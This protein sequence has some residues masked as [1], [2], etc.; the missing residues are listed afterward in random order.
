MSN[1]KLLLAVFIALQ[2]ATAGAG[3]WHN[4]HVQS[5]RQLQLQ[6][7]ADQLTEQLQQES[8]FNAEILT[9]AQ[10]LTA[11][12]QLALQILAAD[13]STSVAVGLEPESALSLQV[14]LTQGR[15]LKLS[16]ASEAFPWL[17]Q[18]LSAAFVFVAGL[19]FHFLQRRQQQSYLPLWQVLQNNT[20]LTET[21]PPG[22]QPL[23]TAIEQLVK[24]ESDRS[25]Q[26]QNLQ[27]QLG[28]T[29][30][31]HAQHSRDLAQQLT[32]AQQRHLHLNHELMCWQLLAGQAEQM[33]P[34]EMRQWLALL[35]WRQQR[36]KTLQPVVQSLSHWFA[37]ALREIQ[38]SWPP[39]LLL[40]PDEDPAATRCQVELD[41]DL[42]R[43][44]IFSLLQALHPLVDGREMQ[45]SY[46]LESGTRDK[47][48]LKFQYT[49]KS[50]S[51]R[52]RQILLQ[53]PFAE[54][55]WTDIAFELCHLLVEKLGADLQIQ[56]LADLGT[57][58][59]CNV[60][61]VGRDRQQ[62]KR[63]QNL[64]VFDPRPGW[65]EIWRQSLHGVSEQ[66]VATATVGEL[67][68][69]LTSRLIDT[70]VFHVHD[71]SLSATDLQQL[72][73]LSLRY[74]VVVFAGQPAKAVFEGMACTVMFDSPL[75]LAD[76]QDLPQPGCQFAN[77][78][79]LIVDDNQTNLSFV[80]A[81]LEG[82]GINI[83]FAVTGQEALKL[84]SNSRYQLI[85]MDIQLPDLSGVE[86]TKRIR[87]LRHHQQTI[88]LAFTGH[89][90]PEEAASFRLAGM[91]DVM[92]KPL[93]ARKIAHILSRVRP[94]AEIQ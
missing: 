16:A 49:G 58:V 60:P 40:L 17:W 34:A 52:S 29:E 25:N 28:Q 69:V 51:A 20:Q 86:V 18:L 75:L 9:L 62:T 54:P 85:L 50:L 7:L 44:L 10:H 76:L 35:L 1:L 43:Y 78:Q 24:Q 92:I 42:M 31:S 38:Q 55:Q 8:E 47:L 70:I 45:L 39:H 12:P 89:A 53:G 66:V 84:A 11:L 36:D 79:L 19:G 93:D 94:M 73:Q 48:Q 77:Q 37:S 30:L 81:M 67:Q 3:W 80:R 59:I 83:D 46:R 74:Q 21:P 15:Q 32:L 27:Q 64:V 26:L 57:R 72:Q 5:A 65:L 87:Q 2:I 71:N 56:E 14:P 41:G 4:Q 88:I 61:V 68:Q 13:G 22:I 82:Q 90:L 23:V 6:Q 33:N 91:D 63:F